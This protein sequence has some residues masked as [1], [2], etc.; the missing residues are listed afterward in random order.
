MHTGTDIAHTLSDVLQQ[1]SKGRS[2]DIGK[3]VPEVTNT[4]V[5]GEQLEGS[6]DD[7]G[8]N[9]ALPAQR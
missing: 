8:E 4:V 7:A 5:L 6:L 9:V 2:N 3:S 1:K